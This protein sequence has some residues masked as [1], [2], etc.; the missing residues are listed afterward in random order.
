[1]LARASRLTAGLGLLSIF[2]FAGYWSIRLA[3]ADVLSRRESGSDVMRALRLVPEDADCRLRLAALAKRDGADPRPELAQAAALK[4]DDFRIWIQLAVESESRSDYTAAERY[5]LRAANASSQFEPRWH[6]ANFYF[7]RQDPEHFWPWARGALAM[8]YD[9]PTPVFRLCRQMPP[10]GGAIERILPDQHRLLSAYLRFLVSENDLATSRKVAL[11]L[12]PQAREGDLSDLLFCCDRML[13]ALKGDSALEIWNGLCRRGLV[14]YAPLQP[15]RGAVLTNGD[16]LRDPLG[17]AFDWC[18]MQLPGVTTVRTGQGGGLRIVFS[19]RQP[20]ICEPIAQWIPGGGRGRRLR[21]DYR[22]IEI[23][24]A[25]GLRW[26]V[27][28]AASGKE[29]AAIPLSADSWSRAEVR[30]SPQLVRL[31]LSYRR[32]PGTTRIEG[33]VELRR[34]EVLVDP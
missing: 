26:T 24:P 10:G 25:S 15:E 34:V 3:W 1:M 23:A 8:D 6:L 5:L 17:S 16:F 13:A 12:L 14:P 21:V 19:G 9:D 29:V 28:N 20:E 31:A 22:T 7:R 18:F 30:F 2:G 32:M 11:R 27:L 33:S 4:P